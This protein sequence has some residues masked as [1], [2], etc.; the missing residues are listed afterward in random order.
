MSTA[1]AATRPSADPA[2]ERVRELLLAPAG[3]REGPAGRSIP[4][5]Y[6]DL[7]GGR[8]VASSG[9]AQDLMLS[10][11]VPRIYERWWRPA[12]GRVLKGPLGP[13]MGGEY[14]LARELLR[15]SPGDGAAVLDIACGTGNF[16]RRFGRVV[17]PEGL[18]VGLDVSETMLERAVGDTSRTGLGNVAYV[19]GD[20]ESPIFANGSFD[21]VCCF[22]ALH[23]FSDPMRALDRLR[24]VLRPG[25]R[26]ALLTSARR[27]PRA[28]AGAESA[29]GALSGMRVFGQEELREA[30]RVRGFEALEW[31]LAGAAQVVG[32]RRA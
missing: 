31:Q 9:R 30:L 17:G 1:R 18:V 19:R 15:L 4:A 27:A 32:A 28:F 14:R 11:L 29:L 8:P 12:L 23:L 16:T 6:L 26:L 22:A 3:R 5:G 2:L 21:A 7:L 10:S 25:G 24:D 13:S 20:A